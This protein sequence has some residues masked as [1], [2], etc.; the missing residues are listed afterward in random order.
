MS[1]TQ[2]I[3]LN[4]SAPTD[5]YVDVA[6]GIPQE[7]PYQYAVPKEVQSQVALGKRVLVPLRNQTRYGYIVGIS[8]SLEVPSAKP[9]Q[10]IL[11]ETSLVPKQFMELAKWMS[12]YYYCS[13]GQCLE[14]AM[15]APFKKGITTMKT[16]P[17]KKTEDDVLVHATP[18]HLK[19]NTYQSAALSA[20]SKALDTH[21]FGSFLLHGV[22]G[23]GKT[24]VYL[25]LIE[26]LLAEG[27]GA[28]VLV[29]EISLTPQTT[30]RFESR[31]PGQVSVIHSRLSVGK[32]LE[33]WHRIREGQIRIVVGAR[34]AIFS[35]IKNL[36][37]VVMDEEHDDS[38]KQAE[39]PRYDAW[40]VSQKRCELENAV[41]LSGSATP[42]LE[43]SFASDHHRK[44]QCLSL[45]KRIGDRPL[46]VVQLIDMRR[47]HHGR[48]IRIF[49]TALEQAVKDALKLKEQ[50]ILF[51]NRRGFSPFVTCITC[52]SVSRCPRCRVAFVFHFDRQML[53]CHTCNLTQKPP[54]MCP[55]CNKGYLRYLGMG[56]EKVEAEIYRLFPGAHVA[57]MDADTTSRVGS[58]KKIL[59]A[60]RK[61][62]VDILLGTQMIAKGHDFPGVSVIGVI[63]ADTA[64][65][66]PDFRSAE[67]T[68]D[69]LTQVAGRAGREHVRGKVFIQTYVPH[70]YAIVSAK[71]HDYHGFF[72][73]E[74]KF[75][76]ELKLPPFRHL[77]QVI[78]A[79][80]NE[81]LVVKRALELKKLTEKQAVLKD[82]GIL[83]PAPCI[84]SKRRGMFLWNLY[85]KG[86][87]AL[88]M[89]AFLKN[90]LKFLSKSGVWITLDVDPR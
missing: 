44:P 90:H 3:P 64:L 72:E 18:R 31:F 39:T 29:P 37:L 49:S 63:S 56:T 43:S 10:T 40:L 15:P 21:K 61:K 1:V 16:R 46:P 84:V 20:L 9:I 22:T 54:R 58:H 76:E 48:Q 50:V 36:R 5:L 42:R 62:E 45:P 17:R 73:K 83:G 6:L 87:D 55:D 35:P 4:I 30:D 7:E 57:R 41:F 82:I 60:F 67:R 70:H 8:K 28:I 85:Y 23:S 81:K 79:G 59:K 53:M 25:C 78:L 71:E 12:E 65:H 80:K 34:S 89:N 74:I 88:A 32:R 66:L 11:D 26:K 52:G 47:E 14:A 38:Y 69:L 24:E 51:L 75:R 77:I 2:E 33:E 86:K 27:G 68:F 13:W 19:L